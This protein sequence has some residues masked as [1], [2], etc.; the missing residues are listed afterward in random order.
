MT[1]YGKDG[2][3]G[4]VRHDGDYGITNT[5]T[6]GVYRCIHRYLTIPIRGS[7][8]LCE[9]NLMRLVYLCNR[10][11]LCCFYFTFFV[12]ILTTSP[13]STTPNEQCTS[14]APNPASDADYFRDKARKDLLALLEGVS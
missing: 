7:E 1:G 12:L 4:E 13:N 9:A 14:M 5:A 6:S 8:R 2:R 11:P 3:S 10:Q